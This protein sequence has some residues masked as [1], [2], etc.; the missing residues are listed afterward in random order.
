LLCCSTE[1][2]FPALVFKLSH[3]GILAIEAK[4][5]LKTGGFIAKKAAEG[6]QL[7]IMAG[8]E[9]TWKSRV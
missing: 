9:Q 6:S 4:I 8:T 5:P 1:R 7:I 2:R 3:H